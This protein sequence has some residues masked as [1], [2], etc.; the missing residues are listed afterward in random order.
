MQ[1]KILTD[2]EKITE[3]LNLLQEESAELIQAVS[4]INRFGLSSTNPLLENSKTNLE[5]LIEEMG[6]VQAL[7]ELTAYHLGIN[8]RDLSEARKDKFRKLRKWSNLLTSD[9]DIE[10]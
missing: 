2:E 7:I 6:D 10:K 5:H 8:S 1:L 3:S 4:K 9:D